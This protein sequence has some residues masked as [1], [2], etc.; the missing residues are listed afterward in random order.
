MPARGACFLRGAFQHGAVESA[1]FQQVM[2]QIPGW[3]GR[4]SG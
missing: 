3:Q 4:P 1:A 2:A